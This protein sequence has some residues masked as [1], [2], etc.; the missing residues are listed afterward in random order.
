[1]EQVFLKILNMS[2]TSS[3]VIFFVLLARIFLKKAPKIFSY[4]LWSAVLFRLICPI[5]FSSSLSLFSLFKND[6]M[7][8]VPSNIGYM[9]QPQINAGIDAVDNFINGSLPAATR[10][11]SI[12]PMQVIISAFSLL[13]IIGIIGLLV[14]SVISYVVLK[15]KTSTALL[16]T[17]NIF[18]CE[19]IISP[20]VLG[21]VKPKIYLPLS[22]SENERCYILAHEKTHIKRLDYLI[23]PFAFLILCLHW[24]NPL[25]WISFVLMSHDMEMSCDERVLKEM[26][27][28][29]KRD[30]SNS[31]LALATY[32]K[33]INGSPLAFGE[34]S[35]KSRIKNV[36]KYKK[37]AL[38][39]LV[40]SVVL[41]SM[42][43]IGLTANPKMDD[44]LFFLDISNTASAVS[45]SEQLIIRIHGAGG[46]IISG[47]EFSSFLELASK[48]W[49]RIETAKPDESKPYLSVYI[50]VASD[51][52]VQFYKSE[53]ELAMVN[54][55]GKY[56][57][58]K[59]PKDTYEKVYMM[60]APRSYRI[61]EEVMKAVID[62]KRTN[63]KSLQDA[64]NNGNYQTLKLGNGTF[65][66][67]KKE[68]KY[69]VEQPYVFISEITERVYEDAVNFASLPSITENTTPAES[70]NFSYNGNDPIQKL[71][72]ATEIEKN[73]SNRGDFTIVA[74]HIFGSYEEGNKLKVFVTT[75]STQ[76]T[77]DNKILTEVGGS[78]I[79]AAITYVKNSAGSYTLEK[80]EQTKDGSEFAKSIRDFCTMPLSGKNIA[81]LADTMLKHYSNYNDIIALEREN[82]IQHLNRIN[83]R[84]IYLKRTYFQKP[85][86]LIPLT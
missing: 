85:E 80:Y 48:D 26:G 18:E 50:N 86:E 61:P 34:S 51:H 39:V 37:P 8:Y 66:I 63:K 40:V 30:Y 52:I 9:S 17:D 42:A 75:F 20:F 74:P 1:M 59:I 22:L 2:I 81:G 47:N 27:K 72:Y 11:A 33:I 45:K 12:N 69:Y 54:Y 44:A 14:Y 49:S 7:E 23:K 31:L 4:C 77:L 78:V 57:Y 19:N 38:W 53:P 28:S 25:V 82:L 36:L 68:N 58:Y 16:I 15:E 71:V 10:Y 24:F 84:N 29:I 67:Y 13:W 55:D 62:G 43:G 79:P 41:V 60:Y 3:Y 56:S 32:K 70:T 6:T 65:F 64:P 76:Y 5:S 83:L 46:T 21:I 73:K 35:V